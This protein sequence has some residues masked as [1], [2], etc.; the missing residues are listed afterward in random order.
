MAND[1]WVL[2]WVCQ[3]LSWILNLEWWWAEKLAFNAHVFPK[4]VQISLKW[5]DGAA[6]MTDGR[7]WFQASMTLC[8]KNVSWCSVYY[9]AYTTW[10]HVLAIRDQLTQVQIA[11]DDQCLPSRVESCKSQSSLPAIAVSP[12]WLN[13]EL[14]IFLRKQITRLLI[15]WHYRAMSLLVSH[16]QRRLAVALVHDVKR[17]RPIKAAWNGH[18]AVLHR[19]RSR[20]LSNLHLDRTR[21]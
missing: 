1:G 4:V 2:Q 16:L 13:Q 17:P 5:V 14:S 18:E 3:C 21:N 10:D 12:M 7:R 8:E 15:C 20:E 6:S 9:T 11:D 19:Q